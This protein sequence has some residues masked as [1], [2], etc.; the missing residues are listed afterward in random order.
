MP[1]KL[2]ESA[3]SI[4]V[5]SATEIETMNAVSLNEVLS[6]VAG[7]D[8]RQRGPLG[9]QADVGIRG[10]S[11]DQT[12]VL[13]NGMK[14]SDPQTGHHSMNL[15]IA[16]ENIDRIE[17]I[18]GPA[19]RIYGPNAFAGAINIVTKPG[20][21]RSVFISGTAGQH[22]LYGGNVT[23]NLP[24]KKLKQSVSLSANGSD[25]FVYNTDFQIQNIMY[26]AELDLNKVQLGVLAAGNLK[27]FGAN[28]FYSSTD[29]RD[30]YEETEAF[31]GGLTAVRKTKSDWTIRG[32]LY[33]RQHDDH[34]VFI[35]DNPSFYEN[36]HTSY[37]LA[38]ELGAQKSWG[39][40]M[41]NL[42]LDTRNEQL[43]SSNLGNRERWVSGVFAD[44]RLMLGRLMLNPGVNVSVISDYDPQW[45]PGLDLSYS[46]NK[47][48][49]LFGS[50]GTSFRVPTYTDLYYVGPQNIGND[51]LIPETAWSTE[52]G[53]KKVSDH[54]TFRT[55]LFRKQAKNG[56]EW[57]RGNDSMPWQAQNLHEV[58]TF[59][60]ESELRLDLTRLRLTQ[61]I[62]NQL[63]LSYTHLN[64]DFSVE[65]GFSSRY[66]IESIRHQFIAS[67]IHKLPFGFRHSLSLRVIDRFHFENAYALVDARVYRQAKQYSVFVE[68]TNL[69]NTVYR[70]TNLVQMPGRWIR[71]GG[72][73][74]LGF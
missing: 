12:L 34:Y 26:Q 6:Y 4:T 23:L 72:R 8:L 52:V 9:V 61:K 45:F 53:I 69:L 36:F 71:V 60:A 14:V 10:G 15:P 11:F 25:T 73:L 20:E 47:R 29:F 49:W 28:A 24:G 18:R 65:E 58:I 27:K 33:G 3:R 74:Y 40:G 38:G 66:Q 51:Q 31:F 54:L 67:L 5:L 63:R 13:I 56:I 70:E 64:S 62:F 37:T 35:R 17:V 2:S 30:Q 21:A 55:S 68:A 50:Y 1:T 43:E 46:I 7:V 44:Y 32:R 48:W 39:K 22:Q 42:G 16:L 41:L 19:A 59:G 57:V